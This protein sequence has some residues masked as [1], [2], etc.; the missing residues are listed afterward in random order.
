MDEQ[1]LSPSPVSHSQCLSSS[2]L[3]L[4]LPLLLSPLSSWS[5]EHN[6]NC[7]Q[8]L[9]S[10]VVKLRLIE[11]FHSVSIGEAPAALSYL[12]NKPR[13]AY[14]FK[15]SNNVI[16]PRF[17]SKF[18]ENSTSYR[19]AI[20]WNAVLTHFTGQ[21]ADFYRKVKKDSYFKELDFSAQSAQSLPRH[22]QDFKCYWI[23]YILRLNCCIQL[24]SVLY[25]MLS[26]F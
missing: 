18:L 1:A 14:N 8:L 6:C 12:A 16:V 10:K 9:K 23:F 20:L 25:V 11:L 19:G 3:F 22:Y 17:N 24:F 21:F 26:L 2:V 4:P 5:T 13:T 15:R 7:N